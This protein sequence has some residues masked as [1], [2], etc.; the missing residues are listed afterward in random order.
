MFQFYSSA[1]SKATKSVASWVLALGLF[2]I[3]LGILVVILKAVVVL[4]IAGLF[5]FGGLICISTAARMFF[6]LFF[7]GNSS[8][9]NSEPFRDNVRPHQHRG[10]EIL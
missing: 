2:L 7:S 5:F 9:R 8:H 10:D 4:F 3:G 1:L 6:R